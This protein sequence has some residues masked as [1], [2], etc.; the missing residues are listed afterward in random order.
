M[1]VQKLLDLFPTWERDLQ[2]P[3]RAAFYY[4]WFPQA[5]DQKNL[6]PFTK[7]YP[8]LGYYSEDNLQV[9]QNHIAAM[10]YGKIQAGIASWWGQ[11]HY[12]DSHISALLQAGE[13]SNFFWAL[14]IESEGYGDPSIDAIRSDLQYIRDHYASSP[15]YLKIGGSFVVFVYGDPGD[16]CQMAA[17]WKQ[18]NTLGA[19]VVLK[20]FPGYQRCAS[21][22]N[23]WHQY[24]P[25][26]PQDQQGKISFTISPGFWK[27]DE[28]QPALKRDI[29]RWSKSIQAMVGSGTN[30][31]LITTY[32][33]WG[34]G[35]AVESAQQW[36]SPTGYGLYLDALHYDGN[37]Q[38][39][40]NP[41]YGLLPF[42]NEMTR[43]SV[44][45]G[46]REIS[47][48]GFPLL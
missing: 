15:A 18:A 23:G 12:T 9:I 8:T 38:K 39:M 34:E 28:T 29:E 37:L 26:N 4:P 41:I 32:N 3:I 35:T 40:C 44:F 5:W 13:K 11:K 46:V 10:R 43:G 47:D 6:R 42:I 21:Q 17:R 48:C 25:A 20:V 14:Y 19:Y 16:N 30:F 33:E 31:Q 7:Y 24:A 27:A 1:R 45:S 22:P 2:F 36:A